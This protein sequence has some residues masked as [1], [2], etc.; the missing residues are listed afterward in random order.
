MRGR[1]RGRVGAD[2]PSGLAKVRV[3]EAGLS[4]LVDSLGQVREWFHLAEQRVELGAGRFESL[5]IE[6]RTGATRVRVERVQVC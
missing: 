1:A 4:Q 6:R 2:Q 3:D 5:F